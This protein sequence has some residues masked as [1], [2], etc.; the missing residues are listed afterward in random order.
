MYFDEVIF[1]EVI[2]NEVIFD[3]VI[4]VEMIFDEMIFDEMIFD[5]VIFDE[6]SE[7]HCFIVTMDDDHHLSVSG[8]DLLI[9]SLGL[10]VPPEIAMKRGYKFPVVFSSSPRPLWT[11]FFVISPK[12]KI[13][14]LSN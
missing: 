2:F 13:A 7:S 11:F 10:N 5:E 1:D 6:V 9:S 4:F 14:F 12:T 8:N 3:E